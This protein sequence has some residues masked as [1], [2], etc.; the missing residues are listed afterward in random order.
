MFSSFLSVLLFSFLFV[1]QSESQQTENSQA[2]SG[3]ITILVSSFNNPTCNG[4]PHARKLC[5]YLATDSIG[6]CNGA[7]MD[8]W[9]WESSTALRH[10]VFWDFWCQKVQSTFTYQRGCNP[11][12]N[13][14]HYELTQFLMNYP[15]LGLIGSE[16]AA[17]PSSS[18]SSLLP[19]SSSSLASDALFISALGGLCVVALVIVLVLWRG[20][21]TQRCHKN[22]SIPQTQEE[23]QSETRL[24]AR[25]GSLPASACHPAEKNSES[26]AL[27]S[28]SA[29]SSSS[30]FSS[31]YTF[32]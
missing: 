21:C 32:L 8:M 1:P 2:L 19:S 24:P 25:T 11:S 4:D 18:S 23:Q 12:Y 20:S 31:S 17:L 6:K 9:T 15:C 7:T 5:R 14:A 29:C 10:T 30:S 27:L 3:R 22:T 16:I 13:T 26:S 28:A